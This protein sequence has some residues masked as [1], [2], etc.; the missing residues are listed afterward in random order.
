[1]DNNRIPFGYH[2]IDDKDEIRTIMS[3]SKSDRA[4]YKT[5]R[6]AGE[7]PARSIPILDL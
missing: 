2:E 3:I 7:N 1:M 5:T 4:A 6:Q